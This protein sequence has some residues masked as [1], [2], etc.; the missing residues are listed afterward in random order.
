MLGSKVTLSIQ[1][2]ARAALAAQLVSGMFGDWL[3]DLES[4]KGRVPV[5]FMSGLD[6]PQLTRETIHELQRE[7]AWIEWHLFEDA[8]QLMFFKHWTDVLSEASRFWR[9]CD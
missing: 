4:L 5:I 3:S 9:K 6:D 8:G 2:S 1:H 7:H